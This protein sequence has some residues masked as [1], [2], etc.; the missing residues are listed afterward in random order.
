MWDSTRIHH[1][2]RV[3]GVSRPPVLLLVTCVAVLAAA[4]CGATAQASYIAITGSQPVRV[5]LDAD[6][7]SEPTHTDTDPH[8]LYPDLT[9]PVLLQNLTLPTGSMVPSTWPTA[10]QTIPTG[11]PPAAPPP[12]PHLIVY[13]RHGQADRLDL[14]TFV[15]S[16]LDPPRSC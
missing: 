3:D 14:S 9:K 6:M 12:D 5:H 2:K 10:G 4:E 11:L 8:P 13:H 15:L 1:I 16:L 7:T